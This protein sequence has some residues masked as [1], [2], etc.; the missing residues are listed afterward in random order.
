MQLGFKGKTFKYFFIINLLGLFY[1]LSIGY[2]NVPS[3]DDWVFLN[4]IE[5]NGIIRFIYDS[6]LT[7]QGRFSYYFIF[8]NFLKIYSYTGSTI[9][10]VIVLIITGVTSIYLILNL[11]FQKISRINNLGLAI[12]I[13]N[14]SI[15]G[16]L[17]FTCFFWVCASAYYIIYFLNSPKTSF[18]YFGLVIS[19]IVVGGGA[20]SFTSFVILFLFIFLVV[21][22]MTKGYKFSDLYKIDLFIRILISLIIMSISFIIMVKAPGNIVR[23]KLY[24]QSKTVPSLITNS[25]KPIT[26]LFLY[27]FSKFFIYLLVFLPFY[28]I[29]NFYKANGLIFKVR[30]NY[31]NLI[32]S[33]VLLTTF[34]WVSLLPGVFAT[35]FLTPLRA[36]SYLS[37]VTI[38][39]I[40]YCG[41]SLGYLKFILPK[42]WL[43]ILTS[44]LFLIFL[45]NFSKD[46][47]LVKQYRIS[48][49]KRFAE[50]EVL[51]NKIPR[52]LDTTVYL[53]PLEY[54]P[55]SNSATYILRYFEKVK[56]PARKNYHDFKFFPVLVDEITSDKNDFRNVALKNHLKLNFDVAIQ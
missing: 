56:Y 47:P 4:N 44:L 40:A 7:W 51:N 34:Y 20:E 27:S 46:V 1:I 11:I 37:L 55:Y 8:S 15:I 32:F 43:N 41:L 14:L 22:F 50:L 54:K 9:Y 33:L 12:F 18:S 48:I 52:G 38:A 21:R 39:F 25:I 36:L 23:M 17:D 28:M 26:E 24:T 13:F 35:S 49:D 30:L 31:K 3:N 45:I 5:K 42:Y 6:Y 29:G 10:I 2:Y 16:A 19:S 53:K